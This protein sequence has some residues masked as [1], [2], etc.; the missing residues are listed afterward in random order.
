MT[1]CPDPGHRSLII[2]PSN[3]DMR[4]IEDAGIRHCHADGERG[5]AATTAMT[6]APV[7]RR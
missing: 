1:D 5:E 4:F 6:T 7:E 2:G 3:R